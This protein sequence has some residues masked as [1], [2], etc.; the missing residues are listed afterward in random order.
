MPDGQMTITTT[1]RPLM[2]V[3]VFVPLTSESKSAL[4]SRL[5][6][7]D[8]LA[9][10]SPQIVA[11]QEGWRCR[12]LVQPGV[13]ANATIAAQ[14]LVNLARQGVDY[15]RT[16]KVLGLAPASQNSFQLEVA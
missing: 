3:D 16:E 5:A 2:G 11:T 9:F 12:F 13:I 14:L 15:I 10:Q 1:A 7:T 8:H 4:A 6:Q